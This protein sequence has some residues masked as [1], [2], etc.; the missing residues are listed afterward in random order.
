MISVNRD[1]K[2]IVLSIFGLKIKFRKKYKVKNLVE[3]GVTKEKRKEKLIISLTSFPARINIVDLAISTLLQQSV[4]PDEVVL[5]LAEEQFPEK[6]QSLPDKLLRLKDFG[7]SIK[8]CTDLKSYKK[9][10]PALKDYS[11]HVIVTVDDDIYYEVDF[12]AKLYNAYLEDPKNIYTHRITRMYFDGS[13]VKRRKDEDYNLDSYSEAS[14]LDKLN[15]CGGVLYPP[16]CFYKDIDRDDIFM[17][18]CKNN[19]DV[20]FWFMGLLGGYK[21]KMVKTP[22]FRPNI[23]EDSQ[24]E[25]SICDSNEVGGD[26]SPFITQVNNVVKKYPELKKIFE[27]EKNV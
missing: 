7:L 25:H 23:V 3:S 16:R 8:W 22:Y 1:R 21:T 4:K 26:K 17:D 2:H 18:I 27:R 15:G 6:E 20:W 12:L 13:M 19:D 10:I 5:W 14:C 11:N 9:L 24:G